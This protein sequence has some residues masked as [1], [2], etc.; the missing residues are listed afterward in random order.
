MMMSLMLSLSI[1]IEFVNGPAHIG[2]AIHV[3]LG[4]EKE[5]RHRTER[6]YQPLRDSAAHFT[7]RFVAI[8]GWLVD[9]ALLG[10]PARRAADGR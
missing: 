8:S 9:R 2:G 4:G 3:D 1:G 10:W 5:M 7:D 6:S